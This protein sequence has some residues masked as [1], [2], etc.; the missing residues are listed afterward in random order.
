[1]APVADTTALAAAAAAAAREVL[2]ALVV[3]LREEVQRLKR[4]G[5]ATRASHRAA[6]TPMKPHR[7]CLLTRWAG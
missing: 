4:Q 1:V 2:E 3:E 7:L 5:E 6:M